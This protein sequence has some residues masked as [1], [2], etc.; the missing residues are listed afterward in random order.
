M[1]ISPDGFHIRLIA[2]RTTRVLTE[3]PICVSDGDYPDIRRSNDGPVWPVDGPADEKLLAEIASLFGSTLQTVPSERGSAAPGSGEVVGIGDVEDETR[4]YAHLTGRS[5]GLVGSLDELRADRLPE[6]IL[7]TAKGLSRDLLT[8][9]M[10]APGKSSATGIIWASS[11]RDLRRQVLMRS[12][13]AALSGELTTKRVEVSYLYTGVT[14]SASGDLRV[15]VGASTPEIRKALGAGAGVLV[16]EHHGDGWRVYLDFDHRLALCTR[17]EPPLD[18]GDEDRS[19]PCV[20]SGHCEFAEE[21]IA[22][23]IE[24]SKLLGP[25]DVKAR[26]LLNFSC[27]AV[28]ADTGIVDSSW[29]YTRKL[30]DSPHVGCVVA[31]PDLSTYPGIARGDIVD[32]LISGTEVGVALAGYQQAPEIEA[33]RHRLLLF[34]DPKVKAVPEAD[35]KLLMRPAI[36]VSR[37]AAAR[38]EPT[39]ERD[40]DPHPAE[41]ALLRDLASV[42]LGGEDAERPKE[43]SRALWSAIRGYDS[44]AG[45]EDDRKGAAVTMRA[46]AIDHIAGLKGRLSIAWL[47]K[48]R[49][50]RDGLQPCPYCGMPIRPF[51]ITLSTGLKRRFIACSACSD[52]VD[53]PLASTL[54]TVVD[55]PEVVLE[56]AGQLRDWTAAVLLIPW[57]SQDIG[58]IQSLPWPADESGAPR[59]ELTLEPSHW[60][61]GVFAVKLVMVADTALSVLGGRARA[62]ERAAAVGVTT[63]AP[64]RPRNGDMR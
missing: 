42:V 46:A 6:V 45:E 39:G 53:R 16:V 22:G 9:L 37:Q 14:K 12:A 4:L 64:D 29:G 24:S 58:A 8:L 60:P 38:S 55:L 7:V 48:S 61:E 35:R 59:R 26:V 1:S 27:H 57:A 10:E 34:G 21:S 15:G 40:W 47:A 41:L 18:G 20:A 49:M 33:C 44:P 25:E 2:P 36:T 63:S 17:A 54:Q 52:V 56:G 32:P 30:I 43:T 31:T 5:G 11:R 23:A 19:P 50:R 3:L 28:L 13:A 51:T 62:P